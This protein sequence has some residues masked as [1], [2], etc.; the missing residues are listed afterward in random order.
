M[1][2]ILADL[3]FGC[4]FGCMIKQSVMRVI[5]FILRAHRVA[6]CVR[7]CVRK[8]GAILKISFT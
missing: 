1:I 3:S 7:P 2:Y 5:W 4:R 6:R 8:H